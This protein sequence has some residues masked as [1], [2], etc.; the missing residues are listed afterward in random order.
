M[1]S[2]LTGILL[3]ALGVVALI[4]LV[5]QF[6]LKPRRL[7]TS[8]A[9][10]APLPA[11]ELTAPLVVAYARSFFPV[12][13][14]VIVFRAFVFEPFHIPS[15]S[16]MPGL[17]DG[18][19]ILVSKFRYGLR[20]PLLNT[21]ITSWFTTTRSRSMVT[22]CPSRPMGFMREATAFP[23]QNCYARSLARPTTIF[24]LRHRGW[25]LTLMRSCR[26]GT[27]SSWVT[28]ATIAKTVVSN[29]LDSCRRII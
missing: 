10:T 12:L 13:L 27:I 11:S 20:L 1:G 16:M 14:L 5:D 9:A 2:D 26:L 21:K 6:V 3:L 17:V 8:G 22:L 19:F 7:A 25:P 29:R 23:E 24:C 15:A 18:D 4:L 28:I